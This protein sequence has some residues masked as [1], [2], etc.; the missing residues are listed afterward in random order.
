MNRTV[1][2]FEIKK[3]D[4]SDEVIWDQFVAEG[5]VNSTFMHSRNFLNY[6]P[7]GKFEDCSLLVYKKGRLAAVLPAC[8]KYEDGVKVFFS[9]AGSTYGGPVLAEKYYTAVNIIEILQALEEYIKAGGF[10]K[11]LLKITPDIFC[12]EKSDVLQYALKYLGYRDYDELS[13][14]ID[15]NDYK[16]NIQDNFSS[17]Q[18]RQLKQAMKNKLSFE[19]FDD[20]E[21]IF[22]FYSILGKNLK[23]FDSKPVHTYLELLDLKNNRLREKILFFGVFLDG[24]MIAGT[25][26]FLFVSVFHTQYLAA[27]YDRLDSKPMPFLYYNVIKYAKEHNFNKLSWGISTEQQGT[28]LNKS[29]LS[30]K[31]SF[32]SKYALNRSFF[33]RV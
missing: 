4:A 33:K 10:Q 6:H 20:D 9:H 16:D 29:L 30:F 7:E 32:G 5:A 15:F 25:M 17:A 24:M 18:N 31:E 1:N 11:I 21:R 19:F 27:D 22:S 28:I 2:S 12:K 26:D 14:Y 8:I 13:T 3:F 23:K